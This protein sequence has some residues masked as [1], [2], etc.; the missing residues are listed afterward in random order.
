M[1]L[2]KNKVTKEQQNINT[3]KKLNLAQYILQGGVRW[4]ANCGF[5]QRNSMSF[6]QERSPKSAPQHVPTVLSYMKT[7]NHVTYGIN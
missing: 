3:N 2:L 7:E 4:F 5:W 6:G 1:E